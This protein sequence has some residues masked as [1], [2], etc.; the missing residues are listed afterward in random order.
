M[1]V[2]RIR[3]EFK[4]RLNKIDSNHYKDYPTAFIDDL[5]NLKQLEFIDL[6]VGGN[7]SKFYKE[8]IES[9]TLSID[10]LSN[11][12]ER[13][14]KITPYDIQPDYV[15]FLLPDNY[16]HKLNITVD[17]NCGVFYDNKYVDQG[18]IL[19][20]LP[21]AYLAPSKLWK[22][23]IYN[24]AKSS[25][26]DQSSIYVYKKDFDI[27]SITLTYVI[28]PTKVFSSG[29]DTLEFISGDTSALN[30]LSTKVDTNLTDKAANY[31]ID[32]MVNEIEQNQ[33]NQLGY[34]L[35]QQKLITNQ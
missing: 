35:S 3:T 8:G 25:N 15:E 32:M 4:K 24:I 5:F 30:K 33:G 12:I 28:K 6:V 14:K 16:L 7:S 34:Q 29:Y 31:I 26:K 23:S 21:D 9:T 17:T 19:E 10:V 20:Y 18:S 27:K 11:L 22:R 13:N 2:E 1:L